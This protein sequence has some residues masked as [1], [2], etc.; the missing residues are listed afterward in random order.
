M[1]IGLVVDGKECDIS[2]DG[3]EQFLPFL[4]NTEEN[5]APSK[6]EEKTPKNEVPLLQYDTLSKWMFAKSKSCNISSLE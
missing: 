6:F 5:S 2:E 1:K 4:M 3:V